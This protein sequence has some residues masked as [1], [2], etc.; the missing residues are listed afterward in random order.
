MTCEDAS[1]SR[2]ANE[3]MGYAGPHGP[4]PET[5]ERQ[6]KWFGGFA[7]RKEAE[8]HLSQMLATLHGGGTI[9]TTKQ[10]VGQFLK[11]WLQKRAGVIRESSFDGYRSI[12][13]G[14]RIP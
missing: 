10:T 11:E 6:R 4:G 7:T 3:V 1:S 9:P 14:H 12:V 2:G 5:G 8:A 13:N